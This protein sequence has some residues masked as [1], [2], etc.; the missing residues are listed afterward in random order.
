MPE[1]DTQTRSYFCAW[2][3]DG[4]GHDATA[5]EL[6][7]H[8]TALNRRHENHHENTECDWCYPDHPSADCS[9]DAC[10]EEYSE[11]DYD[12]DYG[13][14]DVNYRDW[15]AGPHEY[16]DMD[17]EYIKATR[18]VGVEFEM[19]GYGGARGWE[20]RLPRE[21]GI[22]TDHCGIE[23]RTAPAKGEAADRFNRNTL[24]ELLSSGFRS[25]YEAGLHVHVHFPEGKR[26]DD[27]YSSY[28]TTDQNAK[29]ATLYALWYAVEAVT[30]RFDPSRRNNTY[31][32]Q[33]YRLRQA[34][35][36][37]VTE[38][39]ASAARQDG[40]FYPSSGRYNSLNMNGGYGTVE[41]RNHGSS[42]NVEHVMAWIAFCQGIV[43]LSLKLTPIAIMRLAK[44]TSHD[45]RAKLLM[46]YGR[47]H[48]VWTDTAYAA[49]RRELGLAPARPQRVARAA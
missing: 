48:G 27:Y 14:D 40:S 33:L 19:M 29:A 1:T 24:T 9:C 43:D 34:R 45:A 30:Y 3:E 4:S 12:P 7:E 22:G 49:I 37:G 16:E 35:I 13:H 28:V 25:G 26:S 36:D 20:S 46:E 8:H 10:Y 47:R 41:M 31:S 39:L 17:G 21:T 23:V 11:P 18:T 32:E 42:E 2:H 44:A 15:R 38:A 6:N 5:L